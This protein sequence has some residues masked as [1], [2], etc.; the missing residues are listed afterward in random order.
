LINK[1]K[2]RRGFTID[3]TAPGFKDGKITQ[4]GKNQKVA[5]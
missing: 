3:N 5:E 2:K 1:A 4:E